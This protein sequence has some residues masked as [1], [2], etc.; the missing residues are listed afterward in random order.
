MENANVSK[1]NFKSTIKVY[2]QQIL[3]APLYKYVNI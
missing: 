3:Y 1:S 2:I